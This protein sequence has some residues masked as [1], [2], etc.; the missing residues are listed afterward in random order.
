VSRVGGSGLTVQDGL[1]VSLHIPPFA[2]VW[3]S[4]GLTGSAGAYGSKEGPTSRPSRPAPQSIE[5][6]AGLIMFTHAAT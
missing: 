5:R 2:A 1:R 4:Q 3:T 6:A